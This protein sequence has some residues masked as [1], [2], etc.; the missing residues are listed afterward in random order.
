M[1]DSEL[2]TKRRFQI[3][4]WVEGTGEKRGLKRILGYEGDT[5]YRTDFSDEPVDDRELKLTKTANNGCCYPASDPPEK[6]DCR[7]LL[8]EWL[9]ERVGKYEAIDES[10]ISFEEYGKEMLIPSR[11]DVSLWNVVLIEYAFP[12]RK[13]TLEPAI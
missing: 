1:G 9:M 8:R 2:A 10:R 4:D 11:P 12:E 5:A 7:G 13:S 3:G 6:H